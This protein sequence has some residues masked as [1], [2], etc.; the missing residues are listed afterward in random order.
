MEGAYRELTDPYTL[1]ESMLDYARP[2]IKK[3]QDKVT[4]KE[5]QEKKKKEEQ[6]E[7]YFDIDLSEEKKIA[8]ETTNVD[9]NKMLYT[10]CS[11]R[12]LAWLIKYLQLYR[13]SMDEEGGIFIDL[14]CGSGRNLITALMTFRHLGKVIGLETND[15]L[16][17]ASEQLGDRYREAFFDEDDKP[18]FDIYK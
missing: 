14:G 16:V 1:E 3:L 12:S 13:I 8:D 7:E 18:D 4:E 2:V 11:Y 17:K 6:S 10:E 15:K 9:V 5:W